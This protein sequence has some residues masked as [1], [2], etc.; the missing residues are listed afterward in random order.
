MI[1]HCYFV[2][3]TDTE[4]GKTFVCAALL[5]R[6]RE[7]GLTA[8]AFKPVAAGA[9]MTAQGVRNEDAL[10]LLEASGL[11][12]PYEVVNPVCL[13]AAIAPHIAA[14]LEGVTLSVAG[15]E[16][17]AARFHGLDADFGLIEGAGGWRVPLNRRETLADF[18]RGQ[19]C[20][21]ILVVAMRL[22]CIN[23]ALLT[24]EAV[25]RDGLPLAGWVANTPG[26][27]TMG[28]YR[29]NIDTL[30]ALLDAPLLGEI[31]YRPDG[32]YRAAAA[33][34]RLPE[35]LENPGTTG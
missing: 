3:G 6:A 28:H 14:E 34:L 16:Q 15:L 33:C 23:H 29:Q 1:R 13:R 21:V 11:S 25:V 17:G 31:A 32:D 30:S 22:G 24:A 5:S 20:G 10:T 4:V 19:G 8:A 7:R 35:G 12:V 27:V 2:T 9:E 18:A 26:R